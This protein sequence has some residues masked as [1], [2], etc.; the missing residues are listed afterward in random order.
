[1]GGD[2]KKTS[3]QL[4]VKKYTRIVDDPSP[5]DV[6]TRAALTATCEHLYSLL[7]VR[8][9]YDDAGITPKSQ[10]AS[11]RPEDLPTLA[12]SDFLWDRLRGVR[13]DMS[14]QGFNGDAWA[15]TR[16]EEMARCAIALEYLLCEQ[17]ASLA[18]PDGHDSHLHVEQLGKTLGTLRGV[19]AEIRSGGSASG[20]DAASSDSRTADRAAD[21][22]DR[23]AEHAAYQILLKLDDHGPFKKASGVA[24]LR[25]ARATPTEVLTRPKVAFALRCVPVTPVPGRP[26]SRGARRSLRTFPGASLRQAGPPVSIP[27]HLDASQ[28]R[29]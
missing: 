28:L 1:M 24:F 22:A 8:A 27:T 4:A 19:Y 29:H 17:R 5:A 11:T 12:R 20:G 3:A 16:L 18:A 9:R 7:G 10:W 2:R 6:R 21:L 13:Q 23:E 15:A 14:L 25:D 26:R